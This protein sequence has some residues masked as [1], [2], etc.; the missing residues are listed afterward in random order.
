M[1][2]ASRENRLSSIE[3]VG[4]YQFSVFDLTVKELKVTNADG[5]TS[6]LLQNPT[7]INTTDQSLQIF[8]DLLANSNDP[9]MTFGPARELVFAVGGDEQLATTQAGQDLTFTNLAHL[10]ELSAEDL[11]SIR[12]YQ[13]SDMENVLW[14]FSLAA[15]EVRSSGDPGSRANQSFLIRTTEQPIQ[16]EWVSELRP[17][18]TLAWKVEALEGNDATDDLNPESSGGSGP[19]NKP[20][21]YGKVQH[22]WIGKVIANTPAT[23]EADTG[24]GRFETPWQSIAYSN[25]EANQFSFL[26]DM[27][28][29]P[30][31]PV[32]FN[33]KTEIGRAHV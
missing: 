7:T 26:P 11:L 20:Y 29:E 3:C 4:A 17:D 23:G 25:N 8:Y 13:N 21:A 30:H 12:L 31:L 19:S 2:E 1:I 9:L 27:T 14:E 28:D 10:A 5:S 15:L 33:S 16:V 24:T 18:D 22:Q 6:D 32:V